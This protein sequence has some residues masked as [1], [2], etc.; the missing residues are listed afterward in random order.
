MARCFVATLLVHIFF[1]HMLLFLLLLFFSSNWQADKWFRACILETS[2]NNLKYKRFDTYEI[3]ELANVILQ[4]Q[5]Q[6][7]WMSSLS[8][9]WWWVFFLSFSHWLW[10]NFHWSS[11]YHDEAIKILFTKIRKFLVRYSSNLN[12]SLI[13]FHLAVKNSQI[14]ASNCALELYRLTITLIMNC[15]SIPP[16]T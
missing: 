16:K 4:Q 2:F 3:K 12:I 15:V 14:S 1:F 6:L 5:N 10:R 9:C 7:N 13:Q 8:L 11:N